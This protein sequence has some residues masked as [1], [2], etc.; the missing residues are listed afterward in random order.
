MNDKKRQYEDMTIATLLRRYD[1]LV[2]RLETLLRDNST[3]LH[4]LLE[5]ERELTLREG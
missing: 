1:R 2:I 5:M 4:D 3:D